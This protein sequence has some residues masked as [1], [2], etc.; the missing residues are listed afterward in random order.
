MRIAGS[1]SNLAFQSWPARQSLATTAR[2]ELLD[3]F[4][5]PAVRGASVAGGTRADAAATWPRPAD[6]ILSRTS[7]AHLR[8]GESGGDMLPLVSVAGAVINDKDYDKAISFTLSAGNDF[9]T[10]MMGLDKSGKN[11]VDAEVIPPEAKAR[12]IQK[13]ISTGHLKGSALEAFGVDPKLLA[14]DGQVR[15]KD[16]DGR[17]G[18]ADF[19]GVVPASS[20]KIAK[21]LVDDVNAQK[22][23]LLLLGENHDAQP[24]DV[25]SQVVAQL[26]QQGKPVI[27]TYELPKEQ[28]GDVVERLNQGPMSANERATWRN[29][30]LT[31]MA[32]QGEKST[33]TRPAMADLETAVGPMADLMLKNQALGAKSYAID[34]FTVRN[35]DKA[36]ANDLRALNAQ[37]PDAII[38]AQLGRTHVNEVGTERADVDSALNQQ[39]DTKN[40]VGRRLQD[41]PGGVISVGFVPFGFSGDLHGHAGY[42]RLFAM[43]GW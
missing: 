37:H 22:S 2:R 7:M 16:G 5:A 1:T 9:A 3:T 33:G 23:H 8:R 21:T 32:D 10:V 28:C 35:R 39:T 19:D 13:L 41:I 4:E 43:G 29:D 18:A 36:M 15:D 17:I 26:R 20:D 31:R 34:D 11:I 30:F 27:A 14:G 40:T 42:D 38:V 12:A 24:L 25:N 6:T